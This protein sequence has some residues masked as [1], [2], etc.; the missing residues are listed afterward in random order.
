M[1]THSEYAKIHF[2]KVSFIVNYI[3]TSLKTLNKGNITSSWSHVMLPSI[4]IRNQSSH[5]FYSLFLFGECW[6]LEGI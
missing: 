6:R 4:K 1:V 5:H 2:E 3:T